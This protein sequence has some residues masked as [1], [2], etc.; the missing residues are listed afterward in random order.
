M[1]VLPPGICLE[2]R[3]HVGCSHIGGVFAWNTEDDVCFIEWQPCTSEEVYRK[4]W[5]SRQT[6]SSKLGIV[7]CCWWSAELA[8]LLSRW[9]GPEVFHAGPSRHCAAHCPTHLTETPYHVQCSM[10]VRTGMVSC[11]GTSHSLRRCCPSVAKRSDSRVCSPLSTWRHFRQLSS[12]A[13]PG[14]QAL[15]QRLGCKRS[16]HESSLCQPAC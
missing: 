2:L 16:D 6:V 3:Q 15:L 10:C 11:Q 13:C 5:S 14:V 4:R 12:R 9:P 8:E 1:D 7:A